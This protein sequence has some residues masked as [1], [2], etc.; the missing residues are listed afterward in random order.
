MTSPGKGLIS[1]TDEAGLTVCL[2]LDCSGPTEV[3]VELTMTTDASPSPRHLRDRLDAWTPPANPSPLTAAAIRGVRV[4]ELVAEFRR[5]GAVA[6]DA[7]TVFDFKPVV[8]IASP[9]GKRFGFKSA[10]Q[11]ATQASRAMAA[12]AYEV[13]VRSGRPHPI[14][15]VA[16]AMCDGDEREAHNLVSAARRSGYLT[17]GTPGRAGGHLTPEGRA[18]VDALRDTNGSLATDLKGNAK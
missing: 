4:G 8:S 9:I 6:D 18:L 3:P 12:W 15:F 10:G 14:K 17:K 2:Y 11:F 7:S 16:E 13:A 1:W 5:I